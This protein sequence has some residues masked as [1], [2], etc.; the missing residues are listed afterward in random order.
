M[1]TMSEKSTILVITTS[2]PVFPLGRIVEL[3][4]MEFIGNEPTGDE[5]HVFFNPEIPL[6]GDFKTF[7][8]LDD[9]F[10]RSHA[11]FPAS[12]QA[13]RGFLAGA[14]VIMPEA[15]KGERFLEREFFDADMPGLPTFL[16]EPLIDFWELVGE[17]AKMLPKVREL[18]IKLGSMAGRGRNR[19]SAIDKCGIYLAILREAGLDSQ[20][21]MEWSARKRNLPIPGDKRADAPISPNGLAAGMGT[22]SSNPSNMVGGAGANAA[23]SQIQSQTQNQNQHQSQG[24]PANPNAGV[25]GRPR[26]NAQ[27]ARGWAAMESN[28]GGVDAPRAPEP[29]RANV[30][31]GGSGNRGSDLNVDYV[32]RSVELFRSYVKGRK[33]IL[34]TETTGM[35]PPGDRLIEFAGLE[36]ID[37]ELTGVN[38]HFYCNPERPIP[39]GA[40]RI[41]GL[42]NWKLRGAPLFASKAD[43]MLDFLNGATLVIHNAPFD[44][45]FINSELGRMGRRPLPHIEE[46][47]VMDTLRVA[48]LLHPG[49]SNKLDSL[50]DRY[51]VNRAARVKHGAFI[52]CELLFEVWRNLMFDLARHNSKY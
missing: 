5:L 1:R 2:G 6:D 45:R 16:G 12:A 28:H 25:W 26:G 34:D 49:K 36:A 21:I 3:G 39:A 38:L 35:T 32:D 24:R 15:K 19:L 31:L 51:G 13:I 20:K 40:T 42:T 52:D 33:I 43:E 11:P 48:R 29:P 17:K 18:E 44:I 47:A 10:L 41:H 50:C 30:V 23:P 14:R 46:D 9:A 8:G 27:E 22:G 37:G 7:E 4:A